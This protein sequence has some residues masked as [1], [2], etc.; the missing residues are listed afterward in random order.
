MEY[1]Y[2]HSDESSKLKPATRRENDNLLEIMLTLVCDIGNHYTCS[3]EETV[4]HDFLVILKR[5]LKEMFPSYSV[6][7]IET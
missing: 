5:M 4:P 2:I 3:T 1:H 7:V 6:D